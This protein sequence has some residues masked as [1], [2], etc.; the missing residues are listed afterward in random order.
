MSVFE[1]QNYKN[2]LKNIFTI[3]GSGRG[4]RSKLAKHIGCQSGF[5]SHI[6][7]GH[8]NF[9][10]EQT[11]KVSDF[12]EHDEEQSEFFMLLVQ[13]ERAGSA[14]LKNHFH[15]K[16]EEIILKRQKIKE[17][18][19]VASDLDEKD[20]LIY[21]GHWYYSAIHIATSIDTLQTVSSLSNHLSLPNTVVKSVL[22]FLVSKGLVE[23]EGE[24]YCIGKARIHVDRDSPLFIKHHTNWRL[25][26]IK[27]LEK[28]KEGGL[29]YSGVISLSYHDVQ[30]IREILLGSIEAS[31]KILVESPEETLAS[32][33]LD[34]FEL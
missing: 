33:S 19:K 6:L 11:L 15:K 21:Y 2:Y 34:F 29:H 7:N 5:I 22:K 18:I 30:R 31:E 28:E 27:A 13:F 1:H 3:D 4:M 32:I 10:L 25:E 17:R 16:I 14:D 26:A 23:E 12:L 20:Y 9:S 24:R 8:V